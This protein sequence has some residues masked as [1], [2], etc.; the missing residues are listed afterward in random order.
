MN[1][2]EF[3]K[4]C[5]L[6]G[7]SFPV[8]SVLTSCVTNRSNFSGKVIVIGAGAAGLSAAYLLKQ[9]GIEVEVLEANAVHGGRMKRTNTFADFPI[10]T[11][12]EW[13][14]TEKSILTEIVNDSTTKIDVPT[15]PYDLE[16]D[17]ALIDGERKNLQELGFTI[18]QKFINGTWFDFFEEYIVPSIQP[19]IK[20]NQIVQS[21][22][23]ETDQIQVTTNDETFIATKVIVTVPV[24]ILQRQSI[25]FIPK[26]PKSKQ[27][28]ID[29]IIVWNGCKAFIEFSEK[30]YP[31]AI[32]MNTIPESD[33][34][35]LFYDA[36]YGQN[37]TKNILGVFAVGPI[38]NLYTKL[39]DTALIQYILNEL[40]A[41]FDGKAS[42]NYMQHIFQNWNTEPHIHG[43]YVHYFEDWKNI[44]SLGKSVD[45]K[46]FFAGDAYT[47]GNEWS[48]V[49]AA[50]TSAK[51]AVTD[52][53]KS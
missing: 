20:Y 7:L 34:H 43:A 2:K 13:I 14:H 12:A 46:L 1:R 5:G 41:I 47:D 36:A 10:P 42:K 31:A 29:N 21:I 18:D 45:H 33:G 23:Y 44:R 17:F 38:S 6:F 4:L 24:Q 27:D 39:D 50:A 25:Q 52:L 40:D 30:F 32:G 28:A 11:G 26:L 3:V 53:L 49:H 19:K 35:K 9:Q 37:T 22:H 51:R 15:T 8:Q 48:S 16:K